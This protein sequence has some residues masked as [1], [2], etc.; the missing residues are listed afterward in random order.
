MI[1]LKVLAQLVK[2]YK[3]IKVNMKKDLFVA[4]SIAVMIE[5]KFLQL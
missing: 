1:A 3:N 4:L 5:E 2:A